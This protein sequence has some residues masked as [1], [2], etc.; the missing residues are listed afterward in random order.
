MTSTGASKALRRSLFSAYF[1]LRG[2]GRVITIFV[3]LCM[4]TALLLRV[5][6]TSHRTQSID[7]PDVRTF[8]KAHV[9]SCVARVPLKTGRTFETKVKGANVSFVG[10]TAD[11]SFEKDIVALRTH[12]AV[13]ILNKLG[14]A[15]TLLDVGANIGKVTFPVMALP[16]TH[17]VV[18]VEPVGLNVNQLCMTANLNGWLGNAGF[19]LFQAAL[20]DKNGVMDI[21]VPEGREDN[22]A[23][24][25][26]AATANVHR[27]ERGEQVQVLVGDDLMEYGGFSPDFIKIDTQGHE[28]HVLKGLKRYLG[29][30]GKEKV[31]VM[32]ES[33]PKLMKLSRVDPK[34]IYSLMVQ[35]LGYNAY[36]KPIIEA[37][38]GS[39]VVHGT[40]LTEQNYPPGG[41]RD[42]FYFK[43]R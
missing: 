13:R 27:K 8:E 38:N 39:F 15:A 5:F 10:W 43:Q 7:D 18:A 32:A 28:L 22:A 21:Y 31:L 30:S 42:I 6:S 14:R 41:C 20:S 26:E 24:N 34:E 16:H 9:K 11:E 33:D 12:D 2:S 19:H 35:E 1:R 23:L 40:P 29:R 25:A 36:C 3:I 17:T 37:E 4:S